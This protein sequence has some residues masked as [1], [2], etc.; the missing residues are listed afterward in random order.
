MKALG[1]SKYGLEH[2][3]ILN[4]VAEPK[5]A[6]EHDVIVKVT[7]WATNPVDYKVIGNKSDP[8]AEVSRDPFIAG[9]D[10]VGTVEEAGAQAVAKVGDTVWGAGNIARQ[11]SFA[12]KIAV[13][14]RIVANKPSKVGDAEA[15][16]LPLVFLT[17]YEMMADNF[18]LRESDDN[19][20][21]S[22]LVVNGAGGVGSVATQIAKKVFK[23]GTVVA[24]ASRDETA[25]WCKKMGADSTINH[26]KDMPTELAEALKQG[27]GKADYIF[28][29]V[30]LDTNLEQLSKMVNDHGHIGS[31]T[32][33]DASKIAEVV[34]ALFSNS[35]SVHFEFMF[36]RPISQ[37]RIE[38]QREILT[39]AA[40]LVDAG[41]I[42]VPLHRE[43]FVSAT[44]IPE[45]LK[46]QASSKA[47]G[48]L[49][50]LMKF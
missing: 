21:K 2:L 8:T 35:T 12:E 40:E 10:F 37:H 22:L 33:G 6:S 30:D 18:G 5:L 38:R 50:G 9:F 45:A 42:V 34:P 7:G 19:S 44:D 25:E 17:A 24:T 16:S 3:Q 36:S 49:C 43:P 11:G 13:D 39:Y 1:Q 4:D 14:S 15:A 20:G 41:T 32:F 31:I 28:D 29:L 46:I 47:I 27:S 26:R 48:K 23:V